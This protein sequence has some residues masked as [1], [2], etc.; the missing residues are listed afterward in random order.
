M[1]TKPSFTYVNGVLMVLNVSPELLSLA[2]CIEGPD[3]QVTPCHM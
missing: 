2:T 3:A 1:D